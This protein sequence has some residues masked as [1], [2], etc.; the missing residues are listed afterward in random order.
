MNIYTKYIIV[1]TATV[2]VLMTNT[3][4]YAESPKQSKVESFSNPD[5]V[6]NPS[7]GFLEKAIKYDKKVG[8]VDVVISLGQQTYPAFHE[9]VE[10]I[11]KE[12]GIKVAIQQGTCGATAKKLL[13][14]SVD[15]ATYCCPPGKTDRLPGLKFNTVAI[16][17][18]ALVTHKDNPITDVSTTD[19][20]KIFKGEY[21][22]WSEV[23]GF[24]SEIDKLKGERIQPV[25]RMH[26][27]KR[28]GHWRSLMG[29]ADEVSPR[30][31]SVG[32]IPD[33]I[34]EVADNIAAIGYETPYM[35]KVHKDKGILKILSI[36]GKNPENVELL[37]NGNYPIYRAYSLTTWANENNKNEKAEVLME[38]I[39][40]HIQNHGEEYGF[41]PAS[42]LK[43]AG[44]KFNGRELIAEP[45][46]QVVDSR[47]N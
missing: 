46:G 13:K 42:K 44:W 24:Q 16:A 11:A 12:K 22:T 2:L 34:T 43:T 31:K 21:V 18:I 37:L 7:V 47:H 1:N 45:N 25:A 23:P 20:K 4:A 19:A 28:P 40:E 41:I 26:C 15:I 30:A 10:R 6:A 27:K 3:L 5:Y 14:K 38:A 8:D 32:T 9:F 36:D 29:S 17:P 35:L 33:T 39:Y